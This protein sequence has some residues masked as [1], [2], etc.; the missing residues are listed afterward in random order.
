MEIPN[1]EYPL[2]LTTERSLFQ[3]HTGTMSRKVKGLNKFR[4]EEL[5]EINPE[6]AARLDIRDGDWVKVISRR[7][8]VSVRAKITEVSQVGMVSMT[9]HFAESP[10]NTITS[11]HLDPVAKIP[12]LKF[13]AVKISKKV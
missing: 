10:T 5:V 7:G 2:V 8:E 9:F 12:E 11:S 13:S 4:G 6:D 1:A 3:Y